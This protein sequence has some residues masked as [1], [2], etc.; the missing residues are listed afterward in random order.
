M[1]IAEVTSSGIDVGSLGLHAPR[2][3]VRMVGIE[4]VGG[5]QDWLRP[6]KV[7][8]PHDPG[9]SALRVPT[10]SLKDLERVVVIVHTCPVDRRPDSC[11]T[12]A[13]GTAFGALR[14]AGVLVTTLMPNKRTASTT[15]TTWG[16]ESAAGWILFLM[17][18][19]LRAYRIR[20]RQMN[21]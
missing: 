3:T 20:H 12:R 9:D 10:S 21:A 14:H 19:Q 6:M 1:R 17:Q 18:V 11:A 15:D 5:G 16:R 13:S 8:D 7:H 2:E 4:R